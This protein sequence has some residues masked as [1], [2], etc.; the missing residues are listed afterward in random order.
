MSSSLGDRRAPAPRVSVTIPEPRSATARS[1][2][3]LPCIAVVALALAAAVAGL[4]AWTSANNVEPPLVFFT[5]AAT[6]IATLTPVN[7]N[8]TTFKMYNLYIPSESAYA[9]VSKRTHEV[10]HIKWN[11]IGKGSTFLMDT[12]IGFRG[13]GPNFDIDDLGGFVPGTQ[14]T[15]SPL[16][17]SFIAGY[18][19]TT[20]SNFHLHDIDVDEDGV[21]ILSLQHDTRAKSVDMSGSGHPAFSLGTH[22]HYHVDADNEAAASVSETVVETDEWSLEMYETK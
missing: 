9:A 1:R 14:R 5:I 8:D 16:A 19:N 18:A 10:N 11:L 17:V 7:L 15:N 4:F 2:R 20:I 13:K 22:R 12:I 21:F 6:G 3:L